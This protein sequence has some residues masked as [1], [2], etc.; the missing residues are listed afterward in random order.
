M[1]QIIFENLSWDGKNLIILF[2]EK[3]SNEIIIK[4]MNLEIVAR[5]TSDSF[6]LKFNIEELSKKNSIIVDFSEIGFKN[7]D[8]EFI[9]DMYLTTN[10]EYFKLV[11]RG[12]VNKD[13]LYRFLEPIYQ[14]GR[15]NGAIPYL[16]SNNE[17][18]IQQSNFRDIRHKYFNITKSYKEINNFIIENDRIEIEFSN[19]EFKNFEDYYFVL[20]DE[21]SNKSCMVDYYIKTVNNTSKIIINLNEHGFW[22]LGNK[23]YILVEAKYKKS[24]VQFVLGSYDSKRQYFD[25]VSLSQDKQILPYIDEKGQFCLYIVNETLEEIEKYQITEETLIVDEFSLN[26]S[27]LWIRV[28]QDNLS[29]LPDPFKGTLLEK[30]KLS[31]IGP[32]SEI[33]LDINKEQLY[34]ISLNLNEVFQADFHEHSL[35]KFYL[36]FYSQ[37]TI[38]KALLINETNKLE[39]FSFPIQLQNGKYISKA[40]TNSNEVCLLLTPSIETFKE[41]TFPYLR[42]ISAIKNL[43]IDNTSLSFS[44]LSDEFLQDIKKYKFIMIEQNTKETFHFNNVK[45][46][47]NDIEINFDS[48]IESYSDNQS[49]WDLHLETIHDSF[50]ELNSLGYSENIVLPRYKRYMQRLNSEGNYFVNP[51]LTDENKVAILIAKEDQVLKEKLPSKK[52]KSKLTVSNVNTQGNNLIF[53]LNF[54]N[55]VEIPGNILFYLKNRDSDEK[56]YLDCTLNNQN[57]EAKLGFSEFVKIHGDKSSRWNLFSEIFYED[58]IEVNRVGNYTNTDIKKYQKY[59]DC[60]FVGEKHSIAAY[61]TNKN[62]I[63]IV[64]RD[65]RFYFTEKYEVKTQIKKLNMQ[66]SNILG[67]IIVNVPYFKEYEIIDFTIK[68]RSQVE[69]EEH[70]LEFAKLND[71]GTEKRLSFRIDLK[72]FQLKQFYYE[73]YLILKINGDLVYKRI[74]NSTAKIKRK[75]NLSVI[76][77]NYINEENCV[78]YLY[79]TP[80]NVLFLAYRQMGPEESSKDKLNELIAYPIYS[81]FKPYFNKKDIWL[82]YEKNSETAQDN[83]YYFFKYC[84]ENHYDKQIYYVIKKDS[85]DYANLKGMEDRVIN[86]MSIKHLIYVCAAKLLVASETRGH[87][88]LWR[89]Q[90]GKIKE[91]LNKKKFVFL[92]HGVTA[93]KLNDSVLSRKSDSA[94]SLY[95]VTSDYERDIISNGLGYSKDEI[96][97]TGFTRWDHLKDKS[98]IQDQKEIFLMPTWRG[99]LDEIPEEEFINTPYFKNYMEVLNSDKLQKILVDNNLKFNFF[100]HPKFKQYI[101]QFSATS[102]NIRII[103]FGEEK[104]NELLMSTSLLITDYSSVAWEVYY[105]KKP[106]IFY[107]FDIDDYNR[108]TGSYINMDEGLFGDR[109]FNSSELINTIES[110]LDNN[111]AEKN[112]YASKRNSYFK[113]IDN[114]NSER[115]YDEIINSKILFKNVNKMSSEYLKIRKNKLIRSLWKLSKKTKLFHLLTIKGKDRIKKALKSRS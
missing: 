13:K 4:Q 115:V 63:S 75:I 28:N 45:V 7:T 68:L 92:Q 83:S 106:V 99:W 5:R 73:F 96:I 23:Y 43:K 10:S 47:N 17:I 109:V 113:Y 16:T 66:G 50:I 111:F 20:I 30:V 14:L 56:F 55:T 88:Y 19:S 98:Q 103:S 31:L 70:S 114:N 85:P 110:Y 58:Y 67:E 48:F 71:K 37:G 94:V 57:E 53:N 108:L 112:A 84:Y 97:V 100:I 87:L 82:V 81:L 61:L 41:I 91:I 65:K 74:E 21:K 90:K 52:M 101:N 76:K 78:I 39:I 15:D 89:H 24:I 79:I 22:E 1:K 60:I 93:L 35:W 27:F 104:V 40:I 46:N 25:N 32:D 62:E 59:Y 42:G 51:Y 12:L 8:E 72:E 86:F 3:T 80:K 77:N 44:L 33:S 49:K 26:D 64:V 9:Y 29:L 11:N 105:L 69:N 54:N 2:D 36:K 95:V 34:N 6:L 107:Q 38:Y 102:E 18:A